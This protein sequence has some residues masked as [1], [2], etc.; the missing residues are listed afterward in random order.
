MTCVL[1]SKAVLCSEQQLSD[2]TRFCSDPYEF[3]I[4]GIDPT[5]NLG[6]F[7][8]NPTAY[9]HLL[10][11]NTA[12]NSPL[13]L[14]PLPVHYHKEFCN[15]NYFSTLIGLKQDGFKVLYCHCFLRFLRIF[16]RFCTSFIQCF[17]LDKIHSAFLCS[18]IRMFFFF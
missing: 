7:S 13:M 10:V 6:D 9:R 17:S 18:C 8:I 11:K 15:Y 5:F 14:G 2:L 4:L 1:E 3:C 12:G 16:R